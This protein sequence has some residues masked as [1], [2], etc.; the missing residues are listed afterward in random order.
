MSPAAISKAIDPKRTGISK[1]LIT[2]TALCGRKGWFSEHVRL[3]D[4]SRV[5]W[6]LP[7]R[8]AFGAA[9]DEAVLSI[10]FAERT[11]T[12]WNPYEVLADGMGAVRGKKTEPGIDWL[13]FEDDLKIAIDLFVFD[14]LRHGSSEAPLVDFHG[15]KLQGLD[16]ES[17]RVGDLIGTPDFI[18]SGDTRPNGRTLILDLKA[19]SRS[20]SE[21]DLRSAELSYYAWLW[22]AYTKGDLP[23][24]GYLTYVRKTKPTYQLLTGSVTSAQ[25]LLAE[26]YVK[27]TRSI[28]SA[29]AQ[30]DV[31]FSTNFCGSCEWRKPNPDAGFEGCSVGSLVAAGEEEAE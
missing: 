20:K 4:G 25:L 9:L 18:L 19:S 13:K 22:A 14:V 23:D 30:E 26:E 29:G 11:N 27:T 3:P 24:V 10:A 6:I 1:S 28:M 31:A 12:S 16:G 15:S 8:V 7:E 21:K 5:P 17:L 2:S